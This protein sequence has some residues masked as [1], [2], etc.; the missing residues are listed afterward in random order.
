MKPKYLIII[1]CITAFFSCK[2]EWLDA[3]PNKSL[4]VPQTIK[5]YQ[6]LLDNSNTVFNT[7]QPALGEIASDDYYVLHSTWQ[8]LIVTQQKGYNWTEDGTYQNGIVNDWNQP[9]AQI[10]H[11]NIILEGIEKI[12]PS[13]NEV[14]SWNNVKGSA[15]FYRAFAF[16]NL[17]QLFAEAYTPA[18]PT[19]DLGIPLKLFSDINERIVRASVQ[20]TYN[21]IIQDLMKAS[22]LLPLHPLYKTRPSMP[23]AYAMLTRTYL[24]MQQYDKA[25]AYADTSLGLY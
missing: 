20:E 23:A 6:A 15:L 2:K 5:D 22:S 11:A 14:Q 19:S 25:L 12:V 24:T 7:G 21:Q 3:K 1:I 8:S 18:T 10:V 13:G 16:Y 9:Y 4:V 17:A